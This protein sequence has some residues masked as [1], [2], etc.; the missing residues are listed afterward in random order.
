MEPDNRV[1]LYLDSHIAKLVDGMTHYIGD[2]AY[3][4]IGYG[5][6]PVVASPDL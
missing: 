1:E 4:V 3:L 2:E 6:R 5:S